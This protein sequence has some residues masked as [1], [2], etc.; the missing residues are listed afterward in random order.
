MEMAGLDSS[1]FEVIV[2]DNSEN[3]EKRAVLDKV[4]SSTVRVINVPNRG[5]VENFTE[6]IHA[7]AGDFVLYLAD[8][9]W[10]S[11][12]GLEQLH[13][14][15][16]PFVDDLS[17][18]GATGSFL[19]E[20]SSMTG[21]LKFDGLDS[22]DAKR[23]LAGYFTANGPNVL[24]Y[25]AVRRSLMLFGLRMMG[26]LPYKFSF[27]DQLM[28]L[29]YVAAGR[30]LQ[31]DRIV[32]FYDLGEWESSEGTLAKD[33]A[34]YLDAGLPVEIDRLHWLICGLE[35]ALLL[36]S[37]MF[38]NQGLAEAPQLAAAWFSENFA[39]FYARDR[40]Q[41][42]APSPANTI[43]QEIKDKWRGISEANPSELLLDL[44]SAFEIVDKK[45]AERYF[46]FWS[47][48]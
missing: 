22:Q 32:Y 36:R 24:F 5:S 6:I 35:G 21:F 42:Y 20:T 8:D 31:L 16:A 12:R 44:C 48:V 38:A 25:S 18:S 19:I 39:R 11:V 4:Q 7:A 37:R 14:M 43:T 28:T 30:V 34:F 47:T 15:A 45:G 46:E 27:H 23:R 41:G 26:S 1:R 9:D 2:R 13:S 33:R 17:I 29:L 3:V 10:L 40:E